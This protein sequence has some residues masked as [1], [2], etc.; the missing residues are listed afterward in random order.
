MRPTTIADIPFVFD[1]SRDKIYEMCKDMDV[2]CDDEKIRR[3]MFQLVESS[4]VEYDESGEVV[5]AIA[6]GS[7]QL[8]MISEELTWCELFFF[9]DKKY[10]MSVPR[11]IGDIQ[12]LLKEYGVKKMTLGIAAGSIMVRKM[13]KKLG[14]SFIDAHYIKR[15]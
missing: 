6:G 12:V 13:Y 14:Y 4:F 2:E 10:R 3:S 7:L 9:V 5:I 11:M 8:M 1:F 15:L